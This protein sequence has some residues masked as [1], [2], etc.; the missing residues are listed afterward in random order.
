MCW[1]ARFWLVHVVRVLEHPSG[2]VLSL[3][4]EE[5]MDSDPNFGPDNRPLH[6]RT[7]CRVAKPRSSRSGSSCMIARDGSM[8][9]AGTARHDPS[10]WRDSCESRWDSETSICITARAKC[11]PLMHFVGPR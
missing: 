11:G 2:H 10:R 1:R 5:V 4:V 9:P 6:V 7:E 3:V 8:P